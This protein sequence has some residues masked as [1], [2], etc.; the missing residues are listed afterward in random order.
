MVAGVASLL[1]LLHPLLLRCWPQKRRMNFLVGEKGYFLN[2]F[3]SWILPGSSPVTVPSSDRLHCILASQW[4]VSSNLS[5]AS[6]FRGRA[7]KTLFICAACCQTD[8]YPMCNKSTWYKRNTGNCFSTMIFKGEFFYISS[9]EPLRPLNG[10][11]GN[12]P[13][14]LCPLFAVSRAPAVWVFGDLVPYD[15]MAHSRK[16]EHY[17]SSIRA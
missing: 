5:E 2:S 10:L 1:H 14:I 13:L 8:A 15:E 4:E 9:L 3:P 17:T 6:W 11:H 16:K 12:A 7:K